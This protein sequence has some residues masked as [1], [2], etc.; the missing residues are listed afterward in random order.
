MYYLNYYL[1]FPVKL[2]IYN[3]INRKFTKKN[4]N[5]GQTSDNLFVYFYLSAS[6]IIVFIILL[7]DPE[8]DLAL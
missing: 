2:M 6:T 5:R 4:L 8:L 7:A 1:F 3:I